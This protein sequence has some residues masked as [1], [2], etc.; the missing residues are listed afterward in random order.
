VTHARAEQAAYN[1]AVWCD[2]VCRAYGK[3]GEFLDG[4]WVNRGEVPRFYP[5]AVTLSEAGGSAAQLERIRDLV[6]TDISGNWAVK[7]SFST[8]DLGTLGFE[9]LFDAAWLFRPAS[10]R[11]PKGDVAGV[12]WARVS[13][14]SE[15]AQWETVWR[16]TPVTEGHAEEDPIFLPS[17][18]MDRSVVVIAAYREEHIV[19]GAIANRTG[20]VVGLTNLFVP[21]RDPEPL[22]AGC[23]A[24]VIEAFPG[25][26]IVGYETGE[27]LAAAR[28]LGFEELRPLRVWLRAHGP[29]RRRAT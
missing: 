8:L 10:L 16:G 13:R 17:L 14:A 1:N 20:D 3:P 22:R 25:L 15:L 5:N 24:R 26:P 28:A 6:D 12:R 27:E 21:E 11:R 4:I 18:L 9:V 23:V 2:I 19:A 7:D 29:E